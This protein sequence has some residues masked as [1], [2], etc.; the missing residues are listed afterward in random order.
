[1]FGTIMQGNIDEVGQNKLNNLCPDEP[2][3]H[4]DFGVV[5]TPD[6][7]ESRRAPHRVR[8]DHDAAEIDEH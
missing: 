7:A 4:F 5:V 3:E 1:M 6:T 2:T 8:G